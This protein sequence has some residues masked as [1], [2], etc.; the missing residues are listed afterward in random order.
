VVLNMLRQLAPNWINAFLFGTVKAVDRK[1]NLSEKHLTTQNTTSCEPF[2]PNFISSNLHV[3]TIP[4][5]PHIKTKDSFC[6]PENG[7]N[8]WSRSFA[9]PTEWIQLAEGE[10]ERIGKSFQD[11]RPI[12]QHSLSVYC[13]LNRSECAD[14]RSSSSLRQSIS[15]S[16]LFASIILTQTFD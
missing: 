4:S 3:F 8:P 1:C 9:W 14:C 7:R 15:S 11:L 2:Q 13:N 5:G 6:S 16:R 10:A 12:G